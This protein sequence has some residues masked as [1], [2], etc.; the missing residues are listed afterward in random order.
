[1]R[2]SNFTAM[3]VTKRGADTAKRF[4]RKGVG[5]VSQGEPAYNCHGKNPAYPKAAKRILPKPVRT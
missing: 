4:F 5:S 3:L 2:F 1:M